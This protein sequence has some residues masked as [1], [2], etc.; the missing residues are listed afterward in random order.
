M[1]RLGADADAER[2]VAQDGIG[3]CSG[4]GACMAMG[5][6]V[7]LG[8]RNIGIWR[9]GRR[10]GSNDRLVSPLAC[11]Y[12]PLHAKFA[13]RPGPGP[14]CRVSER[15]A[16]C[17]S[18]M[19]SPS[20]VHAHEATALSRQISSLWRNHLAG[21]GTVRTISASF[22]T[23]SP[24]RTC[25]TP[26]L[27]VFLC[28][29]YRTFTWTRNLLATVANLSSNDCFFVVAAVPLQIE[30]IHRTGYWTP[31]AGKLWPL[32][33]KSNDGA[34]ELMSSSVA[35]FGGRLAYVVLNRS[36]IFD[37]LPAGLSVMWHAVWALARRTAVCHRMMIDA[38]SVVMRTRPDVLLRGL[39]KLERL[40]QYHRWGRHGDHLF[41]NQD[42]REGAHWWAQSDYFFITS[43]GAF[44]T[45]VALPLDLSS[46]GESNR[47]LLLAAHEA[48]GIEGPRSQYRREPRPWR[49]TRSQLYDRGSRNGWGNRPKHGPSAKPPYCLCL[50]SPVALPPLATVGQQARRRRACHRSNMSVSCW[51]H[52]AESPLVVPIRNAPQGRDG[53]NPTIKASLASYIKG[54]GYVMRAAPPNLTMWPPQLLGQS[55]SKPPIRA[56]MLEPT[57]LVKCVCAVPPNA[58]ID[59][60]KEH[61]HPITSRPT[62][63]GVLLFFKCRRGEQLRPE[64]SWV[65]V[66]PAAATLSDATRS[67]THSAQTRLAE[68]VRRAGRRDRDVWSACTDG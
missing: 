11:T 44:E 57:G 6:A 43:F 28:G 33:A 14:I 41:L 7:F 30:A 39:F 13:C 67:L 32:V 3:N 46:S 25:P 64:G 60:H 27:W 49:L 50:P 2:S 45:D 40:Q 15:G 58:S 17:P 20:R 19:D 34:G 56:R 62:H 53:R 51:P 68:T 52:I 38:S 12:R 24:T 22:G 61:V 66:A 23:W 42:V 26:R 65:P 16:V 36:G 9:V 8:D 1:G 29:H 54:I 48:V 55:S 35:T 63:K 59:W 31:R 10:V 37:R 47:R 4:I 21:Q 5:G 18:V